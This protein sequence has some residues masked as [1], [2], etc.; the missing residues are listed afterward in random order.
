MALKAQARR[1][2]KGRI[3][4]VFFSHD[5]L[6]LWNDNGSA[7][8]PALLLNATEVD[9]GR[10]A[11]VSN[12]MLRRGEGDRFILPDTIDVLCASG[13]RGLRLSAAAGLG[14]RFSYVSPAGQ[15]E[16]QPKKGPKGEEIMP[17]RDDCHTDGD[18]LTLRYVDGGYFENSGALTGS[19]LK[20]ALRDECEGKKLCD[21]ADLR[22]LIIGNG[23]I[24]GNLRGRI[25]YL[26]SLAGEVMPPLKALLQA[27]GARSEEVV[28]SLQPHPQVCEIVLRSPDSHPPLDGV[29]D[30]VSGV[31]LGWVLSERSQTYMSGKAKAAVTKIRCWLSRDASSIPE[32]ASPEV[33]AARQDLCP[34]DGSAAN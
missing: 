32:C 25:S 16:P 15:I 9:H 30:G 14:A 2:I 3:R 23:T 17:K 33:S 8:L 29:S 6:N 10:R 27:H 5:F 24:E 22:L 13:N 4:G 34:A 26:D 11:V 12:I 1:R 21:P 28:A 19:E 18:G 20:T 31:P 7:D